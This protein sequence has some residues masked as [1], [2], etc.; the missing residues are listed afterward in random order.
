MP[1]TIFNR[2]KELAAKAEITMGTEESME[3]FK[4]R[5]RK[6]R[7]I[8]NLDSVASNFKKETPGPGKMMTYVYDP[9]TKDKL[10]YYDTHPLIIMLDVAKGGWY[11][12]NLHYL[13]PKLRVE[14]LEEISFRRTSLRRIASALENNKLTKLCLKRYLVGQLRSQPVTIPKE[15]WEIAIQLP[16]ENFLKAAE[17]TVWRDTRRLK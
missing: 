6:D 12:A 11:G 16:Y 3:W 13:P 17:K 15:E 5:I 7:K 4:N 9:K 10:K 14:I 8:R 1:N 2:Y